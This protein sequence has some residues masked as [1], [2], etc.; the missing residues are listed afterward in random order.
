MVIDDDVII[1]ELFQENLSQLGYAVAVAVDGQQGMELA[2][3]LQPDCIL[4]DVNMPELDGW[5]VLSLLKSN[6][7][8]APIPV[9]MMSMS[10]DKQE[11]YAKGAID[12]LDKTVLHS[13]LPLMLKRHHIGEQVGDVVLVV[14]DDDEQ[15]KVLTM[16]LEEQ[17]LQILPVKNGQVALTHIEHKKPVLILLDLNMPV[18]DGFEF[19]EHL[20][21]HVQWRSI[22]IIVLTSRNLCAEEQTCLN[23]HADM[24]FQKENFQAEELI[25]RIHQMMNNAIIHKLRDEN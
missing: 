13:Q 16:L 10:I 6:S 8:L 15:R 21:N 2:K 1:R 5:Q 9:V 25:L 18:M 14:D 17:G 23:Q 22:P 19:L 3:K 11:G 12:C 4:L 24:I 20:Q 7:L